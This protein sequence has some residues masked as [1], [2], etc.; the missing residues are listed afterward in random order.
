MIQDRKQYI[1]H[2]TTDLFESARFMSDTRSKNLHKTYYDTQSIYE[3]CCIVRYFYS[4]YNAC[5][6]VLLRIIKMSMSLED[7]SP[8]RNVERPLYILLLQ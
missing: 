5:Q 3:D 6:T 7:N 4:P 2:T 1:K 8:D